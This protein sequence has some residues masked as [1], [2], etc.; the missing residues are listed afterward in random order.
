MHALNTKYG[1][2]YY[3]LCMIMLWCENLR[4]LHYFPGC[5]AATVCD[6]EHKICDEIRL[7]KLVKKLATRVIKLKKRYVDTLKS[8]H[9]SYYAFL[10]SV[11]IV[12]RESLTHVHTNRYASFICFILNKRFDSQ[13]KE[14]PLCWR[15]IFFIL[16]SLYLVCVVRCELWITSCDAA[17]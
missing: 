12:N 6:T 15:R 13:R 5:R 4:F 8:S 3:T 17:D 1:I 7:K 16:Y 2:Q 11:W 10:C 14:K 9:V